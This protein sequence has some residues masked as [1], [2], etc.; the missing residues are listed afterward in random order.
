MQLSESFSDDWGFDHLDT[1]L[2]QGVSSASSMPIEEL[3]V[4]V[5]SFSTAG[6]VFRELSGTATELELNCDS[7]SGLRDDGVL[8][9][10]LKKKHIW[11]DCFA[12]DGV[13]SS[14]LKLCL[15]VDLELLCRLT[16]VGLVR[17]FKDGGVIASISVFIL[18]SWVLKSSLVGVV[19]YLCCRFVDSSIS[20]TSS[21]RSFNS[22]R[23]CSKGFVRSVWLSLSVVLSTSH[24]AS[25]IISV[26]YLGPSSSGVLD[27]LFGVE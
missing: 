27:W 7:A 24:D 15:A 12:D 21:I 2:E 25:S 3:P 20:V 23:S 14:N 6:L 11:A 13:V 1:R 8:F 22:E 16:G 26:K 17:C 9:D 19:T 18:S 5:S 10:R 4:P